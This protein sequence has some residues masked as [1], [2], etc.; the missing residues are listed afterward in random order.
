MADYQGTV[1]MQTILH[2][3]SR[4]FTLPLS[5]T[6]EPSPKDIIPLYENQTFEIYTG[7]GEEMLKLLPT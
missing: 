6:G 7:R 4:S 3:D 5:S 1:E 2:H